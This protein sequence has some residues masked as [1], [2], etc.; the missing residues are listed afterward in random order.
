MLTNSALSAET[1]TAP[2]DLSF[3]KVPFTVIRNSVLLFLNGDF[4]YALY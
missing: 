1:R 3:C 2:T 4:H